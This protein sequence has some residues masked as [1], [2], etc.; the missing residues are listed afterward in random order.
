MSIKNTFRI[1]NS[2]DPWSN[3]EIKKYFSGRKNSRDCF[4]EFLYFG[5]V[6]KYCIQKNSRFKVAI[7]NSTLASFYLSN[8]LTSFKS[9]AL[10]LLRF[11]S[12]N[13]HHKLIEINL[14]MK[15]W[16][17][18]EWLMFSSPKFQRFF[19]TFYENLIL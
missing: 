8:N 11:K 17:I 6:K 5:K 4:A 16:C 9:S 19:V 15:K 1:L 12:K 3:F 10:W 2:I 7:L 14:K 13:V 18:F